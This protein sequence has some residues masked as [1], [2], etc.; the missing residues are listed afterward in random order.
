M[1][2]RIVLIGPQRLQPTLAATV[3]SLGVEGRVAAVTAG[4]EEREG[5]D[6][7][8]SEHLGGRTTNL[9][10]WARVEDVMASDGELTGMIRQRADRL[11]AAHELY[12]LRLAHAL[13]AARELL[14]R[15]PQAGFEDLLE[16]EREAALRAVR[17][18]DAS[19]LERVSAI[20]AEFGAEA[21]PLRRAAIR[22]HRAELEAL[23]KPCQVLCVA[24]GHVVVLLHRLALL[25]VLGLWGERKPIV[26]WS[27]GAMAL[28]ERVVL[29]HDDP[30]QGAG[31]AEVYEPGLAAYGGLVPLPHARR[32]L[33]LHDGVRVG[34]MARR[35]APDRCVALDALTRVEWDGAAWRGE[36]GTQQLD[37]Q[38]H[39]TEVRA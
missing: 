26:A 19:H 37:R 4:W 32:R 36:A 35:F 14:K 23:S 16:A 17:V 10:V 39:L 33:R 24:G 2:R 7:E 5:E 28:A 29:F 38:G 34:L 31:N 20:H 22:K 18:V 12:R 27:A 1:A 11:R 30:P 9:E 3:E 6:R 13:D 25:D 15:E 21:Q 8:L